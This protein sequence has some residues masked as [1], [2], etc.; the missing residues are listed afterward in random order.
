N[1]AKNAVLRSIRDHLP[2]QLVVATTD[3]TLLPMIPVSTGNWVFVPCGD[4]TQADDQEILTRY[5]I[6]CRLEGL[7][8]K[9]ILGRLYQEATEKQGPNREQTQTIHV[10]AQEI[11]REHE[12][13]ELRPIRK[14]RQKHPI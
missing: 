13:K 2:P 1:S 8:K 6:A 9:E 3:L 14:S 11:V 12:N 4:C 10:H 7:D 5:V